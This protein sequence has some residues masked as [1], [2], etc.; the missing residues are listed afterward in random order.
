MFTEDSPQLA[1]DRAALARLV[2]AGQLLRGYAPRVLDVLE[3]SIDG[4]RATLQITDE[5]A[6]YETVSAAD[7]RGA[8]LTGNPGRGPATVWMTLERTDRGW[9]IHTAQRLG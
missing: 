1:A 3:V 2:A 7:V 4:D 8:A 9:R 6:D 5:F